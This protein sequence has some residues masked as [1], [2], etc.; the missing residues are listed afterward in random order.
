MKLLLAITLVAPLTGWAQVRLLPR[1]AVPAARAE[2]EQVLTGVM[3]PRLL[4]LPA[5]TFLYRHLRDTLGNHYASPLPPGDWRLAIVRAVRPRWVVVRW[6]PGSAQFAAADTAVYY[7]PFLKGTQT[8][9][10]L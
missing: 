4:R 3:N 2:I 5:G 7:M 10:Q 6:L 9:I 8:I 1:A